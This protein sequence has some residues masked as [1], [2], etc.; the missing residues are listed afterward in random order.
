MIHGWTWRDLLASQR[1]ALRAIA[2]AAFALVVLVGT[3][4]ALFG[5]Q[6]S[7]GNWIKKISIHATGPSINGVGLRAAIILSPRISPR[8]SSATTCPSPREDWQ[9]YQNEA[10]ARRRWLFLFI[11]AAMIALVL[12]A[13][14]RR[15]IDQAALL[16][17]L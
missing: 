6:A 13:A 4:A 8:R 14:R 5:P 9:R 11:N 15:P 17:L 2:G 12:L 10:F 1:P 16:G 3:T 7:W